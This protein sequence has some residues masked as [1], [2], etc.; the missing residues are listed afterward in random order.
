MARRVTTAVVI[1]VIV[2]IAAIVVCAGLHIDTRLF[3]TERG[4]NVFIQRPYAA[5]AQR[6]QYQA[7]CQKVFKHKIRDRQPGCS[8]SLPVGRCQYVADLF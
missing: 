3:A 5:K 7:D 4:I 6:T 1:W 2:C 8:L